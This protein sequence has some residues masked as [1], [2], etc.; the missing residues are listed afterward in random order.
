MAFAIGST[1]R[2]EGA[3]ASTLRE[4]WQSIQM[5]SRRPM[6]MARSD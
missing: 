2:R 6:R 3:R 4:L 5:H 1:L